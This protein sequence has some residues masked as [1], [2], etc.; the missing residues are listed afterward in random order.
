MVQSYPG[1]KAGNNEN[2][3]SSYGNQIFRNL[4]RS[5]CVWFLVL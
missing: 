5:G 1:L 2:E 4:T 3:I